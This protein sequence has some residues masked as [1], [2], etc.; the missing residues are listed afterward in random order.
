MERDAIQV[1]ISPIML[2]I[3]LGKRPR[4]QYKEK[5]KES[6][7]ISMDE[8]NIGILNALKKWAGIDSVIDISRGRAAWCSLSP[9]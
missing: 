9:H 6:R 7:I 5:I 2:D 3:K 8:L 1:D 4:V